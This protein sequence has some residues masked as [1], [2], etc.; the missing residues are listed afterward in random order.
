MNRLLCLV[1]FTGLL[2]IAC[3]KKNNSYKVEFK[4]ES[5]HVTMKCPQIGVAGRNEVS[6]DGFT[7]EDIEK[8]I[9]EGIR[10]R[11]YSGDYEVYVTLLFKDKYGNYSKSQE[12]VKVCTLNGDDVKRYAD[13]NYFKLKSPIPLDKSYP[14]NYDYAD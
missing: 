6:Y 11:D 9:F 12:R 8:E 1:A 5:V 10:N 3:S 2:L 4:S 13:F 14:W 7:S